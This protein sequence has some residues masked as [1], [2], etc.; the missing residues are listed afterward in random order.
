[1]TI[2]SNIKK[3]SG[4]LSSKGQNKRVLSSKSFQE[5]KVKKTRVCR[6]DKNMERMYVERLKVKGIIYGSES[7]SGISEKVWM[8]ISR[9]MMPPFSLIF[10]SLIIILNWRLVSR[11]KVKKK[12]A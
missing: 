3:R 9:L 11:G 4:E 2:K 12:C 6:Q 10:V 7:E 5:M 1:V 8:R